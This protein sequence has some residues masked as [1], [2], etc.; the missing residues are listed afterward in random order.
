[1][2]SVTTSYLEILL[3]DELFSTAQ[4]KH[5]SLYIWDALYTKFVQNRSTENHLEY[6]QH[7]NEVHRRIRQAKC[8]F[9]MR[10][11]LQGSRHSGAM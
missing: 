6:K 9:F 7:R 4:L 10:G 11:A 2:I 8:N 3:Y 1:M 5:H